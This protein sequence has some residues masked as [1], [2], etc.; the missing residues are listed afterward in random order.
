MSG[1]SILPHLVTCTLFANQGP[2]KTLFLLICYLNY[3]WVFILVI[4]IKLI[5]SFIPLSWV[6]FELCQ[7]L[8]RFWPYIS[9]KIVVINNVVIGIANI[10]KVQ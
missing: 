3:I 10:V 9:E 6:H 5:L 4:L 7:F 1:G 2:T 8:V